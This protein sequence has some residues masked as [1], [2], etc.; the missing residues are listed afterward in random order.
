VLRFFRAIEFD[1]G[2]NVKISMDGVR[3]IADL[4]GA[5]IWD[6]TL[7]WDGK[8]HSKLRSILPATGVYAEQSFMIVPRTG[9]D[10]VYLRDSKDAHP[11]V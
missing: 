7:T 2:R 3:G 9:F 1:P 11:I 6:G 4:D 10:M 8:R 5:R